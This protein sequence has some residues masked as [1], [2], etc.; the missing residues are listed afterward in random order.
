[1]TIEP[2]RQV[3]ADIPPDGAVVT[4]VQSAEHKIRKRAYLTWVD[5]GEPHG[6]RP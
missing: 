5:E 6:P 1:M 2:L 3:E 4:D